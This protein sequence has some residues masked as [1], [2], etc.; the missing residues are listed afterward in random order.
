[1]D[2]SCVFVCRFDKPAGQTETDAIYS[3]ASVGH[4]HR[5]SMVYVTPY[6]IGLAIVTAAQFSKPVY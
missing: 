5:P 2:F 4:I 3:Y 6:M 1:M